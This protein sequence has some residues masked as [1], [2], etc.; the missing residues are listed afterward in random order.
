MQKGTQKRQGGLTSWLSRNWFWLG[1]N[2]AA[3]FPLAHLA[4]DFWRDN[5]SVNPIDDITERTGKAAIILLMLSLS[6]TPA[7][8]I[9]G[10]RRAISVRKALG[11]FAFVYASVHLLNFAGYDYGFDMNFILQD[12]LVTKPY[13]L[14]GLL[15]FL[16]LV[17]LAITSTKG[18]MK[19]LG[20]RWKQLH[21]LVYG[22]A[23]AA[24][25]HFFW[26]A[27]AAEDWEPAIYAVVLS[28]LLLVRVPPIRKRLIVLRTG[29]ASAAAAPVARSVQKGT[30]TPSL[31]TTRQ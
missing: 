18:W 13:V 7:A 3:A 1:V 30:R 22:A 4:W 12:G 8:A 25:L 29:N 16:L 20:P 15:A 27:K 31:K 10:F 2:L 11:M 26:L 17:P 24:V 23:G 5:L 9:L 14:A 21:K 6:C 28:V 19:R